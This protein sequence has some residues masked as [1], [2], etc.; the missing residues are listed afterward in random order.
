MASTA[1]TNGIS[2]QA[3][4][5]A[6]E[7]AYGEMTPESHEALEA[8]LAAD[9]RHRG[10]FV[11]ARAWMRATED[12]VIEAHRASVSPAPVHPAPPSGNDNGVDDDAD[13]GAPAAAPVRHAI[14]RWSG[15]AAVA[16]AAMA[17]CVVVLISAGAPILSL[18]EPP[19]FAATE[20]VVK[21]KDG[22]VATLSQDAR[23]HVALSDDY[24]RITLFSGEARFEV[25]KDRAR[26]FVVRSGDVYAQATGTVYSVRRMGRTGGTVKVTEGSVLVWPRDERDQA[27]LVHAGGMVTLD[28]GP[29][30]PKPASTAAAAP[31]LPPPDLAQISLDNV[32]I[33]AAVARFNRVN[34]TKIVLADPA[35]GN[36]AIIG[37]YKASDPEQFA[38]SAATIADSI[39]VHEDGKIVIKPK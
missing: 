3:V 27:V 29:I 35:I 19:R 2:D 31:R 18:F 9:T 13:D 14:F 5:W 11:R 24:R 37:L 21:L 38:Q 32:P 8:W 25:A 20:E 16:A 28:P 23:I 39:V 17:A 33:K 7:Q 34:S 15:R 4:R 30:A 36:V 1:P 12:A 26:P 22:S 6:V 10:A